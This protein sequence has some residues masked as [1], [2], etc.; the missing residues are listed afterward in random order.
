MRTGA[1]IG[2]AERFVTLHKEQPVIETEVVAKERVRMRVEEHVEQ[3]KVRGRVRKE[4]IEAD[5]EGRRTPFRAG[6]ADACAGP[7]PIGRRSRYRRLRRRAC[8][9]PPR[10]VSPRRDRGPPAPGL[11]PRP[12][13]P[14]VGAPPP[15]IRAPLLGPAR[16]PPPAGGRVTGWSRGRYG[17]AGPG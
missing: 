6:T 7:A 3:K 10:R 5:M 4:R 14:P 12:V 8:P 11:F 2:E 17:A 1:E 16:W 15:G 13:H 9:A